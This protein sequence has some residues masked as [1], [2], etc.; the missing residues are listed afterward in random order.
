MTWLSAILER[1]PTQREMEA[2]LSSIRSGQSLADVQAT[3]LAHN[4]VFNQVD[5]DKARY[6]E[7]LHELLLDRKPSAEELAYWTQRYDVHQGIR[8]EVAREFIQSV[9]SAQARW[10]DNFRPVYTF[11][12]SPCSSP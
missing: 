9:G 2:W 11:L 5:R 1:N 6:V 12:R 7:K 3:L 4:Q 8:S 10:L